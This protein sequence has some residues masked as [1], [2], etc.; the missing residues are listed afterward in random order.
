M[1]YGQRTCS[2]DIEHIV[3]PKNIFYGHRTCCSMANNSQNLFWESGASSLHETHGTTKNKWM[4]WG[5]CLKTSFCRDSHPQ[6]RRTPGRLL[7]ERSTK[8]VYTIHCENECIFM[9]LLHPCFELICFIL[10]STF[11]H[12]CVYADVFGS[13]VQSA[14][15]STDFVKPI[16]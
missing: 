11:E 5:H 16:L 13:G 7:A 10:R 15:K 12:L 1:F 6:W 9:S 2:V 8:S 14:S 4:R 3:W